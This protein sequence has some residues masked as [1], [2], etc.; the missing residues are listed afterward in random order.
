[1]RIFMILSLFGAL[2]SPLSIHSLS[3]TE[4]APT[5]KERVQPLSKKEVKA[6]EKKQKRM[7]K[8]HRWMEKHR[9]KFEKFTA[10]SSLQ[11]DDYLTY[12]LLLAAAAVGL[13]FLSI[14]AS[15]LWFFA[16]IAALGAAVFFILWL[17][18]YA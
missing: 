12:T 4:A 6:F 18:E 3:A 8:A 10:Q 13:A 16:G 5:P 9:D 15:F 1:M 11:K 7:A 17:I 14:F 2:L